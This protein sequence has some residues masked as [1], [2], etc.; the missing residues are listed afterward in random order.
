MALRM[1]FAGAEPY[2]PEHEMSLT[3]DDIM[4]PESATARYLFTDDEGVRQYSRIS[5]AIVDGWTI[6][7]RYTTDA[8]DDAALM[9][10]ELESSLIWGATLADIVSGRST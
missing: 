2:A 6:K 10:A 3:R 7:L 9:N 8:P 1:R 4:P 5:V